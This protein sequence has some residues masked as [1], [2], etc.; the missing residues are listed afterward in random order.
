MR[1]HIKTHLDN[2]LYLSSFES[3]LNTQPESQESES[4]S[5]ELTYDHCTTLA[6]DISSASLSVVR[7]SGRDR[8]RSES[9]SRSMGRSLSRSNMNRL[10]LPSQVTFALVKYLKE[11]FSNVDFLISAK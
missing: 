2:V 7:E 5:P 1:R 6:G 3:D 11:V 4:E 10:R 9:R 8:Y